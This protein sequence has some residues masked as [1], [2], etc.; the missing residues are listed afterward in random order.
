MKRYWKLLGIAP[1]EDL[2][3][4]KRAYAKVLKQNRPD[5][6]PEAYQRLREAYDW[7]QRDARRAQANRAS[8]GNDPYGPDHEGA[9]GDFDGGASIVVSEPST[10]PRSQQVSQERPLHEVAIESAGADSEESCVHF[11][12]LAPPP[13]PHQSL[14]GPLHEVDTESAES[15]SGERQDSPDGGVSA[16]APD[17]EGVL[18]LLEAWLQDAGGYET[19]FAIELTQLLSQ[20]SFGARVETE[21][22]CAA[23]VLAHESAP[24]RM[25]LVLAEHFDWGRD[26]RLEQLIGEERAL[27]LY[28]RVEEAQRALGIS[29]CADLQRVRA[30]WAYILITARLLARG[31]A[32]RASLRLLLR[33]FAHYRG[34]HY[35]EVH[36]V[37]SDEALSAKRLIVAARLAS[38]FSLWGV[39][40]GLVWLQ[41][42]EGIFPGTEP[43]LLFVGL[44]A[45]G[46]VGY[47]VCDRL[48]R[49]QSSW[50]LS[51]LNRTRFGRWLIQTRQ[52]AAPYWASIIGL[53]LVSLGTGIALDMDSRLATPLIFASVIG[54]TVSF[55]LL[56][57]RGEAWEPLVLVTWAIL[58]VVL[59]SFFDGTYA[60]VVA[61]PLAA[62]WVLLATMIAVCYPALA[63]VLFF[64]RIGFVRPWLVVF[65]I[66][67]SISRGIGGPVV[68][69]LALVS[70]LWVF[71]YARSASWAMAW[72]GLV[73]ATALF[74][75]GLVS[76]DGPSYIA[77]LQVVLFVMSRLTKVSIWLLDRPILSS[78]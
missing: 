71:V 5:D 46:M 14:D 48:L 53:G 64:W 56:W 13:S 33:P 15:D 50:S 73:I 10:P 41:G 29:R 70:P 7:V 6:D 12:S 63:D 18:G 4:I 16:L 69:V 57:P 35:A 20:L 62:A 52:R 45:A 37:L 39:A 72:L 43:F 2:V 17:A 1:T 27:A 47:A 32:L 22:R 77:C 74:T 26:F 40:L 9:A 75:S 42:S 23:F 34:M 31:H 61:V 68:F 67:Y 54:S 11:A 36:A 60:W 28:L 3:A 55:A 78:V 21:A 59:T 49:P 76:V 8:A 38:F 51:D 58:A 44:L 66:L 25:V 24:Q 65:W 19:S 30:Q